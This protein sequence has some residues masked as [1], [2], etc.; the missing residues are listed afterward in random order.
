MAGTLITVPAFAGARDGVQ[1]FFGTR[2][3]ATGV[4]SS[5]GSVTPG[6]PIGQGAAGGDRRSKN[7]P[8]QRAKRFPVVVSVKQV[9]GTDALILDRPLEAGGTFAG[10]WDALMTNQSGV[11]LT[12]RT[13][14]CVPVLVHD[15]LRRVVA[16]VHAGWR[17]T[18][19]GIVPKTLSLMRHRFGSEPAS[20]QIGIGPSVGPCCYEVDEPV[21]E[22][23]RAGFPDW[24]LVIRETGRNRAM[25][26]LRELVRR[27]AQSVGVEREHI[28]TVRVCTAC[29]PDLFYSYRRDGVVGETMVSGIMLAR[30]SRNT[31]HSER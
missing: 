24:R 21:L 15:P 27:Q 7:G 19:A 1:H 16:A 6:V 17:G 12:I 26:D 30:R 23:L 8:V 18:V 3:Q 22:R 31:G 29:H 14:D 5:G 28:R 11:L 9:H 13:A 10:G 20:L 4:D 2:H 25:L